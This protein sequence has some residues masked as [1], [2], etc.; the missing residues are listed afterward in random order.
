MERIC[1]VSPCVA[2]PRRPVQRNLKGGTPAARRGL[3][4]RSARTRT[5]RSSTAPEIHVQ[6]RSMRRNA[7]KGDKDYVE[8]EYIPPGGNRRKEPSKE[9][10]DAEVNNAANTLL[11]D[12]ASNAYTK[13]F[14]CLVIDLIGSSSYLLPI[15]GEASDFAWAPIE[16]YLLQRL[17]GSTAIASFGFI[18][19]ALPG[20]DFVPTATIAWCIENL[21]G[22]RG[23]KNLLFPKK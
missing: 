14:L 22:L 15:I 23:L 18:E 12:A 13:L 10:F 21:E 20:L 4:L 16:F 17:F 2:L 11:D 5:L 19:E 1:V 8:A 6:L 7:S 3:C 9:D